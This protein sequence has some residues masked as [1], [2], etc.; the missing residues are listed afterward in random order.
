MMSDSNKRSSLDELVTLLQMQRDELKRQLDRA[1]H[2][3]R[4]EYERLAAKCDQLSEHYKPVSDAVGE[5][6]ENVITAFGMVADELKHGFDRV[7]RAI[8]ESGEPKDH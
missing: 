2:D 8:G 7:R 6:T 5:T 3:A 1:G 4:Q